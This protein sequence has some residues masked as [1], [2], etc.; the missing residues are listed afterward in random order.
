[1][2]RSLH[3][4]GIERLASGGGAQGNLRGQHAVGRDLEDGADGKS[5]P[6][7][8]RIR[9]TGARPLGRLGFR[10]DATR[11]RVRSESLLRRSKRM[12]RDSVEG[13]V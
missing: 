10:L 8:N 12:N 4:G 7:M 6:T 9:P 5:I 2:I 13:R 1:V 3:K 11:D